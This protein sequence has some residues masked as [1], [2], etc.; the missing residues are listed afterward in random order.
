MTVIPGLGAV[1]TLS[2]PLDDEG[3]SVRGIA[4]ISE[5]SQL[6]LNFNL[7]YKDM[8]KFDCLRLPY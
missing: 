3:N 7:F 4:M 6:Y 2:P 5:L 8:Q 1:G